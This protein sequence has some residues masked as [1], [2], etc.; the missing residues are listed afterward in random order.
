M[1]VCGIVAFIVL[2]VKLY[3]IQIVDHDK[4]RGWPW[5]SRQGSEGNAARGTIMIQTERCSP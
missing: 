2:A 3:Q 5:N 4:Y 1:T